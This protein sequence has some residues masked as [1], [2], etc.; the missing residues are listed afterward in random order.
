MVVGNYGGKSIGGRFQ[1]RAVKAGLVC[2][3]KLI[4]C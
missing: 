4:L 2:N 1:N 3:Y